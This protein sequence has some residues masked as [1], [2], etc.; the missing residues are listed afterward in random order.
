MAVRSAK[1]GGL[2]S[3][4][5]T[6]TSERPASRRGPVLSARSVRYVAGVV[7]LSGVYYAAGRVSLAL[8]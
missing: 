7:V 8:H 3:A 4:S 5:P 1:E 2:T 6:F